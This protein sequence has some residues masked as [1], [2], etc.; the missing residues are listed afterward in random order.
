LKL[1][2]YVPISELKRCSS[3][4]FGSLGLYYAKGTDVY[5]NEIAACR[6]VRDYL[7]SALTKVNRQILELERKSDENVPS[8]TVNN[9]GGGVPLH[10]PVEHPDKSKPAAKRRTSD[11]RGT[12]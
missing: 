8:K 12:K 9:S 2:A 10:S 6:K 5:E 7:Q 1:S 11:R 3:V 4:L